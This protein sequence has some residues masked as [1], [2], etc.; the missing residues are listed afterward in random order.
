MGNWNSPI[1]DNLYFYKEPTD[2]F[3]DGL[4]TNGDFELGSESWLVGV[5]DCFCSACSY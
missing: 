1:I 4:L 5:D 2:A 3:D